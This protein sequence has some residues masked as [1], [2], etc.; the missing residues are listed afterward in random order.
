MATP[1]KK[2][3]ESKSK[4]PVELCYLEELQFDLRNPRYGTGADKINTERE[5]LDHIVNTFGVNDVLSSI[6]VNGFFDSEP[7]VGIHIEKEKKIRILEGKRRLA[8]CL[9]LSGD[10]RAASQTR[11]RDQYIQIH[12]DNGKRRITPVPVI[13]YRGKNSFKEVL[14]YIG[15]RHIV[16][17]LEWDSYAK[18]AWVDQVLRDHQLKLKEVMEMLGDNNGTAPRMLAGYRFVNQLIRVGQFR[19]DQSQRKGR[20]SNPYYPFSWV[21]TALDNP[22]IKEFVGFIEVDGTPAQNPIPETKLDQAGWIMKFMFG[23]K[24]HGVPA[25][26]EDSREIGD[27]AKAV[28]DVVLCNRLKEGRSL[29]LVMEEARPSSE[30]LQE[31]FQRVADQLRDLTGLIVPGSLEADTAQDLIVPARSVSNLARKA[32]ADLKKIAGGEDE[33]TEEQE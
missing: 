28:R 26:V 27:L 8:A 15:V 4:H 3:A 7:L 1:I 30:R 19:L 11:L 20:G 22:P 32:L 16:G 6:A 18:A 25:V 2:S 10:A 24:N 23:D 14:P 13:V 9:I 29:R 21:Y 5:A 17:F 12:K 31:G 33:S